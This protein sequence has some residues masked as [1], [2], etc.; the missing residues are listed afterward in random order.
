MKKLLIL[1]LL[2]NLFYGGIFKKEKEYDFRYANYGDDIT[3]VYMNEPK[4]T[5]LFQHD[6]LLYQGIKYCLKCSI[7]YKF[8]DSKFYSGFYIFNKKYKN[9]NKYI[10]L[11]NKLIKK[12]SK[13]FTNCIESE[14]LIKKIKI[15]GY[16]QEDEAK[17]IAK[18]Y[19]TKYTLW[20]HKNSKIFLMLSGHRNIV[21]FSI[22]YIE[23]K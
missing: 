11:Y 20:E 10:K 16:L 19:I 18:G 9:K 17:Y 14:T 21:K 2:I 7:L 8:K 23:N 15:I 5:I 22:R 13:E 6:A 1:I 12:M 3:N 4:N